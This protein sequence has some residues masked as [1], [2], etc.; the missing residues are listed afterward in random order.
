MTPA[1]G[2]DS[3]DVFAQAEAFEASA[4]LSTRTAQETRN[5]SLFLPSI[6][7]RVLAVELYLKC[8]LTLEQKRF[9]RKH[10]LDLLYLR[11]SPEVQAAIEGHYDQILPE[12]IGEIESQQRFWQ[13]ISR[14]AGVPGPSP[15]TAFLAALIAARNDFQ[16]YR[17]FFE[18]QSVGPDSSVTILAI[19]RAVRAYILS[20]QPD[21]DTGYPAVQRATVLTQSIR[22]GQPLADFNP[23]LVGNLG[24]GSSLGMILSCF[25]SGCP[26]HF[27]ILFEFSAGYTFPAEA[28]DQGMIPYPPDGV[29]QC[30]TCL[31][32]NGFTP[33]RQRIEQD[34]RQPIYPRGANR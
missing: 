13:A 11:L 12:Y 8:A 29:I 16:R 34:Y 18:I 2:I 5:A 26:H 24:P 4:K 25:N 21:W 27:K 19:S 22:A 7:N 6:V 33:V 28:R 9:P 30:P 3:Y 20:L 10:E 17:Y 14:D 23:A 15:S 1:S 32:L 31:A